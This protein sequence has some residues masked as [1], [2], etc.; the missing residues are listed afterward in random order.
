[1]FTSLLALAASNPQKSTATRGGNKNWNIS[2]SGIVDLVG[3]QLM[4]Q[5]NLGGGWTLGGLGQ[6]VSWTDPNS[7][8]IA[9]NAYGLRGDYNFSGEAFHDG[10]YLAGMLVSASAKVTT[11]ISAV[12]YEG[13]ATATG[14]NLLGGYTW[15]WENFNIILGGGF[16]SASTS[17][18]T[19]K[20]SLGNT[21]KYTGGYQPSAAFE[22]NLGWAF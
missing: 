18:I 7:Y 13:T 8:K 2:T 11:T 14:V 16:S 1:M 5:Y 19:V 17:D 21:V 15:V 10:W 22:F 20:D 4:V 9:S 6:T 12:N 3:F